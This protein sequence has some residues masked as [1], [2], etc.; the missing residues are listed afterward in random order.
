VKYKEFRKMC[1]TSTRVRRGR[2]VKRIPSEDRYRVSSPHD[3]P[4]KRRPVKEGG[5]GA[6]R[7]LK[8]EAGRNG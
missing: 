8:K 5:V 7:A 4:P 3:P 2:R 1:V 6:L